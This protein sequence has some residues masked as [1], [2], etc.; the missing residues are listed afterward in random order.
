[1]TDPKYE[2]ARTG[3]LLLDLYND[4][5]SEGQALSICQQKGRKAK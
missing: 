3:L 5:V 1:M 4:F 2:S